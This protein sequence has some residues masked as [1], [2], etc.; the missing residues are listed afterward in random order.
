[1]TPN[2]SREGLAELVRS[3]RV[4]RA[5]GGE[6]VVADDGGWLPGVFPTEDDAILSTLSANK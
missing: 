4:Y 2:T 6:Y 3:I 1:M 5:A